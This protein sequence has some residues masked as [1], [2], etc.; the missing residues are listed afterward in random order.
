LSRCDGIDE[1]LAVLAVL[2]TRL[3]V[4]LMMIR[5][6]RFALE[7]RDTEDEE[8]LGIRLLRCGGVVPSHQ[9]AVRDT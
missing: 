1:L 8:R 5:P 7:W 4:C 2:V 6:R 9:P 3:A